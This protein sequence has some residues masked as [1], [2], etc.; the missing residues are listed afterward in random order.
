MRKM[1]FSF[2]LRGYAALVLGLSTALLL[3]I[4]GCGGHDD[5]FAP[6]MEDKGYLGNAACESC[7]QAAFDAHKG[8]RHALTIR[9]V[10]KENMGRYLPK[11]GPIKG[12]DLAIYHTAN[13]VSMGWQDTEEGAYP[14]Q[15]A[16]GSDRHAFTYLYIMNNKKLVEFRQTY[17]TQDKEWIT[18]PGQTHVTGRSLGRMRDEDTSKKC[19]SCHVTALSSKGLVPE[20]KF[21]GV[22]CESCHGPGKRHVE[23]VN[24]GEKDIHMEKLGS[25]GA[26]KLN[27]LCGRC[28]RVA[29]DLMQDQ[30]TM[31]QRFAP[32]GLMKS[33]CFQGSGNTLSC[34][35]CHD[36]HKNAYPD[37]KSYE[38]ACLKCHAP[39]QSFGPADPRRK[40]CPV[41]PRTGCIPCHMPK[42][43]S[44]EEEPFLFTEH[45]IHIFS[46]EE[47]ERIQD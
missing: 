47:M 9:P 4:A 42:S 3:A 11:E 40:A 46:E 18:T 7:H 28:H 19:L 17:N 29:K 36:P 32:Y 5:P 24:A 43:K 23:A 26:K 44:S 2:S 22:G 10:D 15:Y 6:L 41:N 33:R 45:N 30:L 14:M 12:S 27:E 20:P 34:S 25:L 31:T 16:L 38:K 37:P 39:V 13:G 35:A 8:S 21:F 1:H